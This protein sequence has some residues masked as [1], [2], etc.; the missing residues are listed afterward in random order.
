MARH[1]SILTPDIQVMERQDN[2]VPRSRPE[3]PAARILAE[4]VKRITWWI[5]EA[6]L[7][8]DHLQ[9]LVA[10]FLHGSFWNNRHIR[11][12]SSLN[13]Q[14]KK[15][16]KR[17]ERHN[18]DVHRKYFS[19]AK[20]S[21][22]SPRVE[23]K[24]NFLPNVGRQGRKKYKLFVLKHAEILFSPVRSDSIELP[25]PSKNSWGNYCSLQRHETTILLPA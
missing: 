6:T 25:P 24:L 5:Y 17:T 19:F 9:L 3:G 15:K 4:V 7:S 23:R 20:D 2:P 10:I 16:R 21:I 13:I 12:N 14:K 1:G 22:T 8:R 18:I 11:I